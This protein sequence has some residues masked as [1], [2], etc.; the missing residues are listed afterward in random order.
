MSVTRRDFLAAGVASGLSLAAA[1]AILGAGKTDKM[2]RT[3]VIGCGWWG[4]V[5]LEQAIQTGTCKPVALCN[6]DS[7]HLNDAAAKVKTLTG[8]EP[9]L[10]KD[11]RDLLDKEKPEIVIVATPDHW[12]AL[13]MIA[14]VRAGAHVL[15]EKPLCHTVYEGKAML[16]A[17]REC[18]RVV[19]VGTHR[20][21]GKHYMSAMK[22]LKEGKVGKIG[23]VRAFCG[24]GGD[25]K[26]NAPDEPP[27]PGLDWDFWCGPAPLRPYN[28]QIHP[29]GFRNFLDFANG[30]LGDWGHH[31][32][33]LLLWWTEE[34]YPK[35]VSCTGGKMLVDDRT[36]APDTQ[37]ATYE[38]ESF[39]AV[40]EFRGYAGNACEKHP[41]GLYFY[42][43]NGILHLGIIDGWT[44][45][46]Y[47]AKPIHE[48]T[49]R[50]ENIRELWADMTHAIETGTRPVSDIEHGCL[51]ANMCLLGNLS[52]KVGRSIEW[53]G[54][55]QVITGDPQA[56]RLLRRDYRA[57]GNIPTTPKTAFQAEL[58]PPAARLLN[59]VS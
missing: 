33:D 1:P 7:N 19:Q 14:A 51:A 40:W 50:S 13:P 24:F 43:A 20:R 55:K 16:K 26:T 46:P 54:Q 5:N 2:Y 34:R 42:G 31:L 18:N 3:A 37:I 25:L 36:D 53:D 12:H 23:M 56:N 21:L 4:M 28:R 44:F 57:P 41:F 59:S 32:F 58:S 9:K 30:Q 17:A 11:Y 49:D 8:D 22:F 15:V 45:Y 48:N 6:V 27:P 29:K 10:Y 38:F 47:D 52:M 35:K 39:R